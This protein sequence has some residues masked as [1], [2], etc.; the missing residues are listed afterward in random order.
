MISKWTDATEI[1]PYDIAEG[2]PYRTAIVAERSGLNRFVK[3]YSNV[4]DA[5]TD[6]TSPVDTDLSK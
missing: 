1:N 6:I 2:T 4:Q 3:T 5:M